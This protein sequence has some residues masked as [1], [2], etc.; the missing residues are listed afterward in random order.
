MGNA[1]ANHQTPGAANEEGLLVRFTF[2]EGPRRGPWRVSTAEYAPLLVDKDGPPVR[3]LDVG[4][5]LADPATDPALRARLELARDRTAEVVGRRGATAAG[6]R[7][8]TP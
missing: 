1:V 8:I 7:P 5:A 4:R 2:T 6:L 3:L